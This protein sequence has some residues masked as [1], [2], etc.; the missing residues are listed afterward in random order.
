MTI[1]WGA[2]ADFVAT[3][4][5]PAAVCFWMLAVGNN[6]TKEGFDRIF[7]KLTDVVEVQTRLA[8]MLEGMVAR[9]D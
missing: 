6:T 7:D 8:T 5:V 9:R 1:D 4:G 2:V 3:V